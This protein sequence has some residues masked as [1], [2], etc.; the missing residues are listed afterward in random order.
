MKIGGVSSHISLERNITMHNLK[1]CIIIFQFNTFKYNDFVY[2][3]DIVFF[4]I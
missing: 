2:R 4:F 3:I 1:F